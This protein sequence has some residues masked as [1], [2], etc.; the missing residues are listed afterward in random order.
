MTTLTKTLSQTFPTRMLRR[1]G[2]AV[3]SLSSQKNSASSSS[4]LDS[5]Y[6]A[7]VTRIR[8]ETSRAVTV[9]FELLDGYRLNYKAGQFVTV[10]FPVGAT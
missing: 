5:M 4:V 9:E 6:A 2:R 8:R 7:Q 1:M 10:C 3:N